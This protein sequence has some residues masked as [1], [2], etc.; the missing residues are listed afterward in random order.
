M[1]G[2]RRTVKAGDRICSFEF[3]DGNATPAFDVKLPS[4]LKSSRRK[5]RVFSSGWRRSRPVDFQSF[6][7]GRALSFRIVLF[8]LDRLGDY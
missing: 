8:D 4:H 2:N 6:N 7:S 5:C 1:E 3:I